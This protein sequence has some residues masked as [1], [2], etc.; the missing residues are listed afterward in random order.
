MCDLWRRMGKVYPDWEDNQYLQH[1]RVTKE[2]FCQWYLCVRYGRFF[3]KQETN[4]RQPLSREKRLAIV[5]HWLV[6]GE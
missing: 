5:L 6:H 1:Y 2:S 4:M 3:K